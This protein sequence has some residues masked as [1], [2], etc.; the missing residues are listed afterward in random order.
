MARTK[1]KRNPAV[2]PGS[3]GFW[4]RPALINLVADALLVLAVTGLTWAASS[5][6]Q[7]LPFFQL[8][9]V[10][11]GGAIERVTP[12][13]LE[14][15]TRVALTGNF[16]TIDLDGMRSAYEKL[17]WVRHAEVRRRWPDALDLRI[18]EHQA[19]ARW[20]QA[21]G[22]SRLVN[23]FGEVFAAASEAELPAFAGPEGSAQLVL[24][25]FRE[26]ERTLSVLGRK[27]ERV[28]LSSRE[29]WQLKLD[30]GM[31][32]EL[33]RDEPKHPLGE[34]LSRFV[35]HYHPALER[36]RLEGVRV[37]DMRYP[38]GFALKP[39]RPDSKS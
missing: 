34:R 27:P 28:I 26:F 36:T 22:E 14:Q 23:G 6:L 19:V 21:D 31:V 38:N 35:S 32:L 18:E 30:D 11:V 13:Q 1:T 8:R 15:A 16:F 10:V 29:A 2:E 20:K 24:T 3:D 37:A 33:G 4:D 12:A 7:R 9:Q 39:G 5:V 25:R 17:P